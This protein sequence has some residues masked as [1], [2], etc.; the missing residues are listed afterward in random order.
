M[1][2][3]EG[4]LEFGQFLADPAARVL[5]R[6]GQIVP[7][8]P[9]AFDLLLALLQSSGRALTREELLTKIWGDIAVEEANLTQAMSVLRKAL[10]ENAQEPSYIAT[11]PRRGYRFNADVRTVMN[12][13]G[14][15]R[16]MVADGPPLNSI[17]VLPFVNMSTEADSE[18]FSDGLTE[19]I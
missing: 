13:G 14:R 7:L 3:K 19:E 10:G 11:L 5:M 16:S 4:R 18:F 9:R 12:S 8:P 17:V 2:P 15:E 6:E 1:Y